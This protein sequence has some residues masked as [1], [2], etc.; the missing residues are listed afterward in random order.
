[1]T[2]E[3]IGGYLAGSLAVMTDAAHLFSDI[4]GFSISILSLYLVKYSYKFIIDK[5]ALKL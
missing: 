3:F 1:M 4:S 2:V 5:K